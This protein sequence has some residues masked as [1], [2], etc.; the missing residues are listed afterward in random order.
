MFLSPVVAVIVAATV[1]C[2]EFVEVL[3]V[4]VIFVFVL[5]EKRNCAV[6]SAGF[7]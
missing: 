2:V 7:R 6:R 3:V 4:S 5:C 1:F